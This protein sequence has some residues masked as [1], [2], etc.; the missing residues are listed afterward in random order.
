MRFI[1]LLLIKFY[2]KIIPLEKR[3]ICIFKESCSSFVYRKTKDEGIA[4][5]VHAFISRFKKCKPGFS[6]INPFTDVMEIHL[7]DGSILE[8][9]EVSELLLDDLRKKLFKV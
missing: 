7:R 5:G 8:K 6:I 9:D 2:W 3:R 1:F 4:K